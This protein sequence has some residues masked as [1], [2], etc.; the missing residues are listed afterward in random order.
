MDREK[1]LEN[2]IIW[3]ILAL[4][5]FVYGYFLQKN[6]VRH[7]AEEIRV[8]RSYVTDHR[9]NSIDELSDSIYERLSIVLYDHG[10]DD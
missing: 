1:K 2:I 9:G 8:V 4:G 6:K 3:L 5:L 7:F 10:F